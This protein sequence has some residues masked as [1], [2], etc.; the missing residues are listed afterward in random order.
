MTVSGSK[1][2][3]VVA[4]VTAFAVVLAIA[5]M[6]SDGAP[7]RPLA[8][9]ADRSSTDAS[10]P[11]AAR[12][13][14]TPGEDF[15]RSDAAG[16]DEQRSEVL[17][18]SAGAA[19]AR[20]VLVVDA[21]TRSAVPQAEVFW[22]DERR[23]RERRGG[24]D[25]RARDDRHWAERVVESGVRLVADDQGQV[26]LPAIDMRVYV[27]ARHD[28][29]FGIT[30][31]DRNEREATVELVLDRIVTVRVTDQMG[32]PCPDVEVVLGVDRAPGLD[33]CTTARTD[34]AGLAHLPHLQLHRRPARIQD[35]AAQARFTEIANRVALL[36]QISVE[37]TPVNQGLTI[38]VPGVRADRPLREQLRGAR[39]ELR[40][41]V[42]G[43]IRSQRNES[44][45]VPAAALFADF[46]VLARVPQLTPAIVEFPA[47]A[48]P[49]DVVELRVGALGALTIRL[50]GPG[51]APLWSPCDVEVTRSVLNP[52]PGSVEPGL[53][54]AFAALGRVRQHKPGGEES[55][56]F[57]AIGAGAL[58]DVRVHFPDDDFQF[59]QLGIPGPLAG[60]HRT[61][62]V[63]VP[64]WFAVLAGR[65]VDSQRRPLALSANLLVSSAEGRVEGE[66]ITSGEN[67]VFELPIR[68][69]E[70]HAPFTLE[71]QARDGE[72]PLGALI[73]LPH[74]E[75][76]SR[77]VIGD[78]VIA[79][80]PELAS[81]LVHDD[82]GEAIR[83]A[84][85]VLQTFHAAAGAAGE[86]RDVAYVRARSAE[87]GSFRLF[88]ERRPG[89][90]RV[91]ARARGHAPAHSGELAFGARLELELMR[92]GTLVASG[93]APEWL[94]RGAIDVVLSQNGEQV[95]NE[96]LRVNRAAA[97]HVALRGLPPGRYELRYELQGI[98]PVSVWP[99]VMVT[100]GEA[101]QIPPLDL[102]EAVFR[103]SV[104][105]RDQAGQPISD[106]GSPL[107][108][109]VIDQNGASRWV[110]F[111]WRGDHAEFISTARSALVVALAPGHRPVQTQLAPGESSVTLARI[112]DVELS[113]PG[114]RAL[115]GERRVRISLVFEGDTGLPMADLEAFD[116]R[117]G[118]TRGYARAALGKSSGGWLDGEDRVRMPLMLNGRY[119]VIARISESGRRGTVS[120]RVGSIDVVADGPEPP[121][122]VVHPPPG[123][124]Q[125]ALAELATR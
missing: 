7:E 45:P 77:H 72:Q 64:G 20:K 19:D 30:T 8:R 43:G 122:A 22:S 57:P 95:R 15:A 60:E 80:L 79:E 21:A 101:T 117:R 102:R 35:P 87:D 105:A 63:N 75:A 100:A 17:L 107:L 78:L 115:V 67:G 70:Q 52:L 124:V 32:R 55:L 97:F 119:D 48:L 4:L 36:E 99:A 84:D 118:R 47:D 39:G 59:E 98:G 1:L 116:Q 71:V 74:L 18:A 94:P 103:Y 49:T 88:G 29:R 6:L 112:Q 24:G 85:V 68:L 51:P 123:V 125:Q 104:T 61:V 3:P 46:V 92:L 13:V 14:A 31:I 66:H 16:D 10:S 90:L 114:L 81:G 58:V 5:W 50:V 83:R 69:R 73:D 93:H 26:L 28:E 25:G 76:G 108:A 41:V 86:W 109:Q 40:Q 54:K 82:R 120:T 11:S 42:R 33:D 89:P 37:Q 111:P 44:D 56:S 53:A 34:A 23:L 62:E 38:R 121:R 27:A 12:R 96:D 65:F 2:R 110:A 113:L 91:Q 9:A 106:P